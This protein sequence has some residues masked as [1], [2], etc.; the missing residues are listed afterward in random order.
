MTFL[1][2]MRLL[3]SMSKRRHGKGNLTHVVIPSKFRADEFQHHC[4]ANYDPSFNMALIIR[5]SEL[6]FLLLTT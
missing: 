5:T 1:K 4:N 3:I 6:I 2:C